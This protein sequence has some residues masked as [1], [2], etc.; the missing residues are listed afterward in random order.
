MEL[1]I[2]G[3]GKEKAIT[4]TDSPVN[5]PNFSPT[6]AVCAVNCCLVAPST[7]DENPGGR[8]AQVLAKLGGT[9]AF[10]KNCQGVPPILGLL[11][12]Y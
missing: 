8:V 9:K 2:G 5:K 4:R 1:E 11:H 10:R 6:P 7:Q 3:G 12:F